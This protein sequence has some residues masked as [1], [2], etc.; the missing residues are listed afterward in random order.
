MQASGIGI[1]KND[2]VQ[3]MYSRSVYIGPL[4]LESICDIIFVGHLRCP[5]LSF[6]RG[7]ANSE[8]NQ[9]ETGLNLISIAVELLGY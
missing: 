9:L 2:L 8:Q 6:P 3:I 7:V 5:V 1:E 4:R